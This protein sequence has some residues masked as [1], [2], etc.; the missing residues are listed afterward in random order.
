M[1][2]CLPHSPSRSVTSQP[3]PPHQ[4]AC[5]GRSVHGGVFRPRRLRHPRNIPHME[6][7]SSG[8]RENTCVNHRRQCANSQLAWEEGKGSTS[9]RT[10][11]TRT[12]NSQWILAHT[13][14]WGHS[15]R[16]HPLA[17]STNFVRECFFVCLSLLSY[18]Y[19]LS[20]PAT[21]SPCFLHPGKDVQSLIPDSRLGL[22]STCGPGMSL[23]SL[24]V[25][26]LLGGVLAKSL[27]D[28]CRT[29]WVESK[30]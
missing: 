23:Q 10:P 28:T 3:L 20:P 9:P 22:S 26:P 6:A 1:G 2:S 8:N 19:P 4:S 16:L 24:P 25:P 14:Q 21:H 18:L 7:L 15:R 30:T 27:E 17:A 29:P 11:P 5:V 13:F 12:L